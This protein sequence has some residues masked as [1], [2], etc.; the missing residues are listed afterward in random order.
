MAELFTIALTALVLGIILDNILF[1][2]FTRDSVLRNRIKA[3]KDEVERLNVN[4][5]LSEIAI[6]NLEEK[7]DICEAVKNTLEDEMNRLA[8]ELNNYK[9]EHYQSIRDRVRDRLVAEKP[10]VTI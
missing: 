3:L 6:S 10:E 1:R 5:D 7:L 9:V 4:L 2:I 8:E